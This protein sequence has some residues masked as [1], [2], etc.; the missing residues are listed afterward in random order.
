MS[1]VV[2]DKSLVQGQELSVD[3]QKAILQ[4][5]LTD[6]RNAIVDKYA[7]RSTGLFDVTELLGI[8]DFR[9]RRANRQF[10]KQVLNP[11]IESGAIRGDSIDQLGGMFDLRGSSNMP[12]QDEGWK[13]AFNELEVGDNFNRSVLENKDAIAAVESLGFN[14]KY[15]PNQSDNR[16]NLIDQFNEETGNIDLRNKDRLDINNDQAQLNQARANQIYEATP[17]KELGMNEETGNFHSPLSFK[18]KYGENA[19]RMKHVENLIQQANQPIND[20]LALQRKQ[21]NT[22][23]LI[24]GILG[25]AMIL[26]D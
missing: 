23:N 26:S 17:L 18:L 20:Q 13:R 8:D 2:T 15:V 19:I 5:L 7:P 10:Q 12:L 11:L 22:N 14:S 25:T 9:N 4:K 24:K 6:K 16:L 1:N 21:Q 3:D